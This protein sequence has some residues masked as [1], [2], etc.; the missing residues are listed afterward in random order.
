MRETR[1][2]GAGN[3]RA[4]SVRAPSTAH[5][6]YLSLGSNRGD[7][8]A[9]IENA[10]GRLEQAGVCIVKRSSLYETEP[11]GFHDQRWFLNCV[12][13]A[14][15]SLMPRQL[16][17]NAQ[18][19]ERALGRRRESVRNAPR[20]IDIDVLLFGA[21]V[22]R[23]AELEIPHPRIA[24]RRFVLAPLAEIAPSLR[25]PTLHLTAVELLAATSDRSQVKKSRS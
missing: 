18:R 10:L 11:V 20:N 5:T 21:T 22:M 7:R 2:L 6:V 1:E 19:I 25:H 16:V 17:R 3:A 12:V 9:Q 15:T 23:T 4:N 24:E 8:V 14:E 13:Q